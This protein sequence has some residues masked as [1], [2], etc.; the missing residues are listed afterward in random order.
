MTQLIKTFQKRYKII[1]PVNS[2]LSYYI[3]FNIKLAPGDKNVLIN[4]RALMMSS[5]TNKEANLITL[6]HLRAERSKWRSVES[7]WRKSPPNGQ[8]AEFNQPAVVRGARCGPAW[9][10]CLIPYI[11]P[12]CGRSMS[13][14]KPVPHDLWIS[15]TL[16]S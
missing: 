3:V 2:T 15:A 5:Q 13:S 12:A 14:S 11:L 1:T 16:V 8:A 7:K 10:I 9:F 6:E 4:A